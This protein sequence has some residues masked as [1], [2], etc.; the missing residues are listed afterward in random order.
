MTAGRTGCTRVSTAN[1]V[2][3]GHH[4]RLRRSL[5]ELLETVGDLKS[6]GIHLASREERVDTSSS[7]GE[8]VFQVFGAI[9]YFERRLISERTRE[10]I[11]AAHGRDSRPGHPPVDPVK[12]AAL[13]RLAEASMIPGKATR[14]LGIGRFNAYRPVR[15]GQETADDRGRLDACKFAGLGPPEWIETRDFAMN[16][17][18]SP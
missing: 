11:A 2:A 15:K 8:L 1:H 6:R 5:A 13:H 17:R 14:Q 16:C 18:T 3:A 7:V 12:V 9:A 10:G 4:D